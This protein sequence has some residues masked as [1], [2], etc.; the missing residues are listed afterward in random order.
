M[1]RLELHGPVDPHVHLRDLDWPHKATFASETAAA[2][3]GGYWAVMDM[4][5]T[6]PATTT[7]AR[8]RAKKVRLEQEAHCDVGAWL[9]A[10]GEG[11]SVDL[12]TAQKFTVA[13]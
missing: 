11:P 4:P 9:G 5:N 8:L 2:L 6:P 12:E 7:V 3:A 1:S 10:A 13:A